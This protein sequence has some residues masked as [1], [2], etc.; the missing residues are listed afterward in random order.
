MGFRTT[1]VASTSKVQ[2]EALSQA[3]KFKD[4]EPVAVDH[5]NE[6]GQAAT[7]WE[8]SMMVVDLASNV[9][10]PLALVRD[11]RAAL[12]EHVVLIAMTPSVTPKTIAA[13]LK[14]GGDDVALLGAPPNSIVKRVIQ[15]SDMRT[16]QPLSERRR[17]LIEKLGGA[18]DA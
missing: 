14:A 9:E 1:V 16:K 3:M 18:G 7:S 6:A 2:R 15:W 8:A 13:V 4:L 11:M 17:V 12:G 5:P 10:K